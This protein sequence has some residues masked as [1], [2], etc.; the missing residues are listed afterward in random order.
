MRPAITETD[1][2]D[3]FRDSMLEA[4]SF[5]AC[6]TLGASWLCE[7]IDKQLFS[8]G[9]RATDVTDYVEFCRSRAEEMEAWQGEDEELWVWAW[10][11][12]AELLEFYEQSA[13]FSDAELAERFCSGCDDPEI[14]GK[15]CY[16]RH[17]IVSALAFIHGNT[18]GAQ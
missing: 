13:R 15:E 2:L 10:S 14:S 5:R 12:A 4:D 3:H 9:G 18:T 11:S 16:A 7:W 8:E 6:L 1:W 17:L